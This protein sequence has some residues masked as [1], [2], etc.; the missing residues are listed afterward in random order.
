MM[1]KLVLFTL[2]L[3]VIILAYTLIGFIM[4]TRRGSQLPDLEDVEV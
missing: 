2:S 1:L 3:I 4:A